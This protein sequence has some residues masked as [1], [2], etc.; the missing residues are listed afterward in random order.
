MPCLHKSLLLLETRVSLPPH[1]DFKEGMR[2][3]NDLEA[4]SCCPRGLSEFGR[5]FT[6]TSLANI[7]AGKKGSPKEWGREGVDSCVL[8]R[9]MRH[10]TN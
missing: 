10:S 6:E 2:D 8:T 4:K 3:L 7:T 1:P 9:P 5:R